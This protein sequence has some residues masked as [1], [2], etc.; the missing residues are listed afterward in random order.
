[1]TFTLTSTDFADGGQIPT[2]LT[3]DGADRMPNLAW[4]GVPDET[5]EFALILDDPD[6]NGFVHWVVAGISGPTLEISGEPPA[7]AREGRATREQGALGQARAQPLAAA[8]TDEHRRG[9]DARRSAAECGRG[10]KVALQ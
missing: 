10:A 4:S 1:M 2:E 7:G 9:K 3:C 8:A 5:E 6:A